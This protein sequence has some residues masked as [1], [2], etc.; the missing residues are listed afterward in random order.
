[1]TRYLDAY[2]PQREAMG[3]LPILAH[4]NAI[5]NSYA[6]YRKAIAGE[7]YEKAEIVSDPL[8]R[9][10]LAPYADGGQGFMLRN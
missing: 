8:N 6:M 4:A 3:A 5:N 9:F 2:H 10:D 1:M 7:A